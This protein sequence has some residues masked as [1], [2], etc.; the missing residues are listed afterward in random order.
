MFYSFQLNELK[1][2]VVDN[3]P[4]F[5]KGIFDSFVISFFFINPLK[6]LS[7]YST[8]P[9]CVCPSENA[10]YF[11]ESLDS[12]QLNEGNRVMGLSHGPTF[13]ADIGPYLSPTAGNLSHAPTFLSVKPTSC[14]S[15]DLALWRDLWCEVK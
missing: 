11:L 2:I 14:A 8:L 3:R 15:S 7:S 4:R 1:C 13:L 10:F 9:F 5:F 12:Y 6:S